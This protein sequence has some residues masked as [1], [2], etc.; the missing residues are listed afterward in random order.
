MNGVRHLKKWE[1][2]NILLRKFKRKYD[3]SKSTLL[4]SRVGFCLFKAN[5]Y[6]KTIRNL[7]PYVCGGKD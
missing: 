7:Q 4:C 1:W 6:N 5:K 3:V 2:I